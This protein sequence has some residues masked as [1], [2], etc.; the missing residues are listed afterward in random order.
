MG[1]TKRHCRYCDK[2]EDRNL[3]ATYMNI[4]S[5]L[6]ST[7]DSERDSKRSLEIG[8]MAEKCNRFSPKK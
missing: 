4:L 3:C 2:S 7:G 8:E 1:K 5:R 6:E